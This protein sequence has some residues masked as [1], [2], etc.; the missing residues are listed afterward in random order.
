M[1]PI[2]VLPQ[3]DSPTSPKVS[4][5]R[6]ASDT[7]V[8]ALTVP[9]F[10]LG[11]GAGRDGELLDD[12]LDPDEHGGVGEGHGRACVAGERDLVDL[13]GEVGRLGHGLGAVWRWSRGR[14]RPGGST[15]PC[16]RSRV[17]GGDELRVV[18]AAV[19]LGVAAAGREAAVRRSAGRG[20]AAGPGC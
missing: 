18:L 20:R 11:D 19:V 15:R 9:I 6:M 1:R 8:T 5:W 4:P 12:V 3:P 10:L 17:G 7:S 2:V 13:H 14:R 16:G